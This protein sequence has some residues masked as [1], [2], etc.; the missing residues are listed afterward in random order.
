MSAI[1][2][3]ELHQFRRSSYSDGKIKHT[4]A[5]QVECSDPADGTATALVAATLSF[6][7]LDNPD[8]EDLDDIEFGALVNTPRYRIPLAGGAYP[9]DWTC[10]VVSV[11]AE[12]VKDSDTVF[13]VTV[14]YES[15]GDESAALHPL[16]RPAKWTFQSNEWSEPYFLDC[17]EPALPVVNTAG[18]VFE[19]TAE[20]ERA[21]LIITQTVNVEDYD[22][23]AAAEIANTI[24]RDPVTLDGRTYPPEVV[25]ISMPTATK[26]QE[27]FAGYPVDFYEV[28]RQFKVRPEKWTDEYLSYGYNQLAWVPGPSGSPILDRIPIVDPAGAKVTRP[29]P[30]DDE[31]HAI[32]SP[33]GTPAVVERHP[34]R[35]A[36]W[37]SLELE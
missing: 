18:D 27:Y 29:W 31:G 36:D 1:R 6:A 26:Q 33:S 37:S 9:L 4:R 24:N 16:S 14:Q 15:V 8:F 25:K 22:P 35:R 17:S 34:Y 30:L 3:D 10:K 20:R 12:P 5:F 7:T 28:T 13:V 19:Q 23:L 32:P 11:D 2:I 21:S